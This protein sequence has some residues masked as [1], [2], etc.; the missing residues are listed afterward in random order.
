MYIV[1]YYVGERYLIRKEIMK[2]PEE[3]E[4]CIDWDI[5]DELFKERTKKS[6]C[7]M[8]YIVVAPKELSSYIYKSQNLHLL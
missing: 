1:L 6:N 2:V 4:W 7:K 3:L 8:T 5:F